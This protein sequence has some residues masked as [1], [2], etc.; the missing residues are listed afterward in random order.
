MRIS[1]EEDGRTTNYAAGR[2]VRTVG[3]AAGHGQ[4]RQGDTGLLWFSVVR[5][6]FHFSLLNCECACEFIRTS[7]Q[8]I[9][10]PFR[11]ISSDPVVLSRE[12]SHAPSNCRMVFS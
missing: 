8:T 7:S 2:S 9:Q 12:D 10:V 4:D 1:F 6:S 11:S 3:D 5:N